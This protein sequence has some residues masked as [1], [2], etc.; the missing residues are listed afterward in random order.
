MRMSEQTAIKALALQSLATAFWCDGEVS[1]AMR[2]EAKA[3]T[4]LGLAAN[5]QGKVFPIKREDSQ[6]VKP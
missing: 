4:L 1:E 3:R 6:K 5:D 2:V